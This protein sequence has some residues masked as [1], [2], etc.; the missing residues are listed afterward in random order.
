[1]TDQ[2]PPRPMLPHEQ[3]VADA[4]ALR[5]TRAALWASLVESGATLTEIG[6]E[7]GV[8]RE[9]VRQILAVEGYPTVSSQRK[10]DPGDPL[11]VLRA[12]RDPSCGSLSDLSR[13]S[14][15]KASRAKQML[16]MLDRW[17]SAQRLWQ[18]RWRASQHEHHLAW[19]D[20]IIRKLQERHQVTGRSPKMED[21]LDGTLPFGHTMAYRHFGSWNAALTA[22]G[23]PINRRGYSS[24]RRR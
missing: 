22:A 15:Y 2:Q 3:R 6:K 13:L 10:V 20:Y 21:A 8:S 1:M 23:L 24:K 19:R 17:D 9:R 7:V 16:Q 14:G 4:R 5:A 11:V 18:M 12:L